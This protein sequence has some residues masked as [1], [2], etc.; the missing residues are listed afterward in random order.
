MIFFKQEEDSE[1]EPIASVTYIAGRSHKWQSSYINEE[2]RITT[3]VN[4]IDSLTLYRCVIN[5]SIVPGMKIK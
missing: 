1:I 3:D 4:S 5:V 2:L